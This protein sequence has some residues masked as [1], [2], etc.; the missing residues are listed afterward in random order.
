MDE[1][2]KAMK[3]ELA[4]TF[5]KFYFNNNCLT[6]IKLWEEIAEI[7]IQKL[8]AEELGKVEEA[9]ESYI[10][11]RLYPSKKLQE[12]LTILTNLSNP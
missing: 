5:S 3:R 11:S 4:E 7:A 10:N 12:A 2:M 6:G 1:K 8:Y 9:L